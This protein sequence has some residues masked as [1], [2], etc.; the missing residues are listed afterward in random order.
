MI[1]LTIILLLGIAWT[2]WN[3]HQSVHR[4]DALIE[5]WE[6]T[7]AIL[8]SE[9]ISSVSR[10]SGSENSLPEGSGLRVIIQITDAVGLARRFH[11]AGGAG[12]LAPNVL[13]KIM[14]DRVLEETR[15]S[16]QV[17]GYPADVKVIVL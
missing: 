16:M 5:Q 6:E 12:A 14:H 13:K 1:T 3:L 4:L 8:R 15:Q 11:W 10:Q 17:E 9:E 2:L 7:L